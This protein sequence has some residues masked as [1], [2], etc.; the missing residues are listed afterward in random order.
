MGRLLPAALVLLTALGA[1]AAS[2]AAW[3]SPGTGGQSARA[4]TLPAGSTPTASVS[5]RSV[6]VSWSAASLPGGGTV[7]GYDVRRYSTGGVLQS[8]G[9]GCSG[10]VAATSCTETAVPAGSWRYAVMPRQ[11][12]WSGAEGG[13][14]SAVTV[15]APSLS[16][17]PAAVGSLP[18]TL[19]G[20]LASYVAGQ[21]VTFRLDNAS[22]GTV[23]SATV[24][25]STIPA[26]GSA[27]VSVTLPAGTASG[28]HTVYAVGSA[29]D[30]ASAS[31]A[32]TTTVMTSAWDLRDASSGVS[33]NESAAT[34]FS[35]DGRTFTTGNWPAAFSATRYVEYDPNTP[36]PNGRAV[37]GAA[38]TYRRANVSNGDTACFYAE[39]R[40]VS[41]GAVLGTHGSAASPFACVNNTNMSTATVPLPELTTTDL[42]NDARVR[43]YARSSN[44]RAL[45]VDQATVSGTVGTMPFVLYAKQYVDAATGTASAFPWSQAALDGTALSTG[46]DWLTSFQA[47]HYLQV[48]F[49]AYVPAGATVTGAVLRH[50]YRP[51]AN[52]NT[53]CWYAEA[54]SGG[55]LIGTYGSAAAPAGCNA[56]NAV[57]ATDSVSMPDVNS[58]VRA[59]D[60]TVRLYFRGSSNGNKRTQHDLTDVSIS[61]YE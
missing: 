12:N 13:L 39:V 7:A 54:Y 24:T 15:G 48:T 32:V 43:V 1:P 51:T 42:V 25:P 11:G 31:V 59:N 50:A 17:A 53:A 29:G 44:S 40:R 28:A 16:L 5:N 23:L 38:F 8:I 14:S 47:N 55:A 10:T 9:S 18:A 46:A 49:P 21:T 20:S 33:A 60:L 27:S 34:A 26:S 37:T 22:T 35:G 19:S 3:Q 61:Y 52:G 30:S 45:A 2:R 41:T 56:D 36:L 6:T 4:I 58:A 57:Y